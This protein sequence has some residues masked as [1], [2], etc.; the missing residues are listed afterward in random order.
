[1]YL[2]NRIQQKW[3]ILYLKVGCIVVFKGQ[4]HTTKAAIDTSECSSFLEIRRCARSLIMWLRT[5]ELAMCSDWLF[6]TEISWSSFSIHLKPSNTIS[7]WII[8]KQMIIN[9]TNQVGAILFGKQPGTYTLGGSRQ[10]IPT[11]TAI[12]GNL[13]CSRF[14]QRILVRSIVLVIFHEVLPI[15]GHF[16]KRGQ[17][18]QSF[19]SPRILQNI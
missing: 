2:F 19:P 14:Q 5:I 6:N 17:W 9:T 8:T 16:N 15:E 12:S 3:T 13:I 1:M 11:S 18:E 7:K 10:V 4:E